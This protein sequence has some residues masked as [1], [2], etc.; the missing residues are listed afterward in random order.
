MFLPQF[1]LFDLIYNVLLVYVLTSG[2]NLP[3]ILPTNA[4]FALLKMKMF[5]GDTS[6][7]TEMVRSDKWS[8]TVR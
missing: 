2:T 1:I 4:L 8:S 3:K 5:S 6:L 7:K